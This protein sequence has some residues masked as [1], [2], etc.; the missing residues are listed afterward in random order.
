MIQN[1]K[2]RPIGVFDSGVGG[3]TVLSA[4][5]KHLP[6]ESFIYL[7][8]TARLPYGTKSPET[9]TRYAE[10]AS[11]FLLQHGI[12]LLVCACNTASSLAL[13][14][15][16][17]LLPDIP[18][19]GVIE[20]GARAACAETQNN[21]I[22]VIATEATISGKGY[23]RAIQ[24]LL[25]SAHIAAQSCSLFVA[26]AEEGWVDGPI[27]E[28]TAKR[29]LTPLFQ[30]DHQEPPDTLLLGCTHFPVLSDAIQHVIP[31]GV[32][33]IDSAHTTAET[34]VG[35]LQTHQLV[36][37]QVTNTPKTQFLVTDSP[38]R[39][40]RIA[41]QFLSNGVELSDVTLVDLHHGERSSSPP[42]S[43]GL[44]QGKRG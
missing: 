11:L 33:I 38:E 42:S 36:T 40:T 12:K 9:V 17:E 37:E 4:L 34:V 23:H 20:P 10:Q 15:L 31:H 30:V 29:Y 27:V 14:A 1:A 6:Q 22:A 2:N 26:L 7:G 25:P 41:T 19:I 5:Q 16:Q 24:N 35:L 3:L 32:K 18:I 21:R 13:P 28:A 43:R 8:D 44:R 39:F